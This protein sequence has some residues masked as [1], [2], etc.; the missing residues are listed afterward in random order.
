MSRPDPIKSQDLAREKWEMLGTARDDWRCT[1]IW[2]TGGRNEKLWMPAPVFP[3]GVYENLIANGVLPDPYFELNS[4]SCEWVSQ[5]DWVFRTRFRLN[6]EM[7]CEMS[8]PDPNIWLETAIDYHGYFYLNGV[9]LGEHRGVFTPARFNVTEALKRKGE[10]T[11]YIVIVHAPEEQAQMG[12][13]SRVRTDKPRVFYGW[14]F[15]TRLIP[16]GIR[17]DVKLVS[18]RFAWINDLVIKYEIKGK[19]INIYMDT[20]MQA[21]KQGRANLESLISFNGKGVVSRKSVLNLKPGRSTFTQTAVLNNA[22]LWYPNGYG[23]QPLYELRTTLYSAG[24]SRPGEKPG[25]M[26]SR[27]ILDQKRVLTGFRT[28]EL[29]QNE[30]SGQEKQYAGVAPPYTLFVNGKKVFVKGWNWVP[31]DPLYAGQSPE[32][33]KRLI[34]LAK[35]ADV[36]LLRVWGGGLVESR[37]FYELCCQYGIMVWQEFP[38]SSSGMESKP[39]E[40]PGYL[41]F[42]KR[43]A[44]SIVCSRRNYP[45]L[46][47]WCGGNELSADQNTPAIKVLKK[48]VSELDPGRPFLITSPLGPKGGQGMS[49]PGTREEFWDLHGHWLYMGAQEHYKFYNESKPLFHSECGVEGAISYESLKKFVSEE[50][51]FPPDFSN[52]VWVHHGQWWI[53]FDKIQSLFGKLKDIQSFLRASQF[54][55]AEGLRYIVESRRRLKFLCSGVIPWQFNEPWPNTSCTSAVDYYT[56]PK[57]A[58]YWVKNAYRPR[59]LSLQYEKLYWSEGRFRAQVWAHNSLAQTEGKFE[60]RVRVLGN[61]KGSASDISSGHSHNVIFSKS[62]TIL[63]PGCSCRRV[64]DLNLVL[65]DLM[66]GQ[67]KDSAGIFAVS[68][69]LSAG[70]DI[71]ERNDYLFSTGKEQIF[72]GLLDLRPGRIEKEIKKEKDGWKMKIKNTGEEA[73]LFLRAIPPEQNLFTTF[74]SDNFLLLFP[75]EEREIRITDTAGSLRQI[76]VD[77]WNLERTIFVF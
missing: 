71:A 46:V 47:L 45:C 69:F 6:D 14:D 10:N 19:N 62:G 8:R 33:Y 36:N 31:I 54:I 50:R 1:K 9:F 57:M 43:T 32:K 55:Q 52:P 15:S 13:T 18:Y 58:Y 70:K 59:H 38:L 66:Q 35:R 42:L 60:V 17:G 26:R 75:D 4:L 34:E 51:M 48:I 2:E 7:M 29:V 44:R 77:A 20:Q 24:S 49:G 63:L 25:S 28:V 41:E 76:F 53:N 27:E 65:P 72:R 21:I 56:L 5:R 73:I 16:L 61:S 30:F 12:Y 39:S 40:D 22:H 11:L 68:L 67:T 3:L 74:F 37:I 23:G 64:M